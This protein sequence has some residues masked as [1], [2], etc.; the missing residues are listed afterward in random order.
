LNCTQIQLKWLIWISLV[1]MLLTFTACDSEIPEQQTVERGGLLYER[2]DDNPFTGFVTGR[3]QER[4]R[5]HYYAFKKEYKRGI[6]DGITLFWYPDGKLESKATYK[7]GN[8]DGF[9]TSY[10]PDGKPKSRIH[11]VDG[12]RGGS[13]GEMFWDKNGGKKQG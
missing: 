13:K 11:F 7:D 1:L 5:I 3:S 10:W 4:D 12:F 8:I 2:G 6:Q 9:L